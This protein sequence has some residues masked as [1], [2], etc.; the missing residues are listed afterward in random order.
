MKKY[1]RKIKVA[2]LNFFGYILGFLIENGDTAIKVTNIVKEIV[3]NPAVDWVVVM[4]P[5]PLDDL[6]LLKAKSIAPKIAAQVALAMGVIREVNL[7]ESPEEATGKVFELIRDLIPQEGRGIF[8]REF[9]AK[10]AEVLSD[11]KISTAESVA[12]VQLLFKG[13]IK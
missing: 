4:T 11:G 5:T 12:L 6:A 10:V 3:E 1:V 13:I 2:L 8:Y 7:A 9:S